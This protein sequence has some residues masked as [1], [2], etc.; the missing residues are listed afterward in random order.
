MLKLSIAV[1]ADANHHFL[2]LSSE[3]LRE[4]IRDEECGDIAASA[5]AKRR[6]DDEPRARQ[7]LS[8][9]MAHRLDLGGTHELALALTQEVNDVTWLSDQLS[10]LST[11]R[12]RTWWEALL[13]VLPMGRLREAVLSRWLA[14]RDV[15]RAEIRPSRC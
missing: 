3:W 9:C 8:F 10:S 4:L 15:N 13:R 2:H 5:Y 6:I 1:V 14:E 12:R 7:A 11:A